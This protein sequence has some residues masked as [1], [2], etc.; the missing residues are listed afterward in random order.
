MWLDLGL[1]LLLLEFVIFIAHWELFDHGNFLFVGGTFGNHIPK[2]YTL[3]MNFISFI[4][5]E[6]HLFE[7]TNISFI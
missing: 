3:S 4:I 5:Q 2:S 1:S 6:L 7:A